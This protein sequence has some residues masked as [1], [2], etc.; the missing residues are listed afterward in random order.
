MKDVQKSN[1]H[2][3]TITPDFEAFLDCIEHLKTANNSSYY[4]DRYI[5]KRGLVANRTIKANEYIKELLQGNVQCQHMDNYKRKSFPDYLQNVSLR[6]CPICN[7]EYVP[8]DKDNDRWVFKLVLKQTHVPE[9][10]KKLL[11]ALTCKPTLCVRKKVLDKKC[12]VTFA[13]PFIMKNGLYANHDNIN[14]YIVILLMLI[15]LLILISS[16]VYFIKKGKRIRL[17]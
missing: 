6:P 1:N 10:N 7:W 3:V 13:I 11:L 15:L 2:S 9:Q 5:D 14:I 17:V 12:K 4:Q 8:D 16:A